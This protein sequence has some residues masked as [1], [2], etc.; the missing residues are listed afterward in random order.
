MET[1]REVQSLAIFA[2]VVHFFGA[3]A[4]D[5]VQFTIGDC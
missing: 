4:G 3:A 2:V 5:I 1:Q